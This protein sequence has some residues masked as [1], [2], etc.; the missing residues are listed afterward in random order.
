MRDFLDHGGEV[1]S[2]AHGMMHAKLVLI[3]DKAAL[4]GSANLDYRSLF[5][6]YEVTNITYSK[7][8]IALLSDWIDNLISQSIPYQPSDKKIRRLLENLTR[9]I[10]PIL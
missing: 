6:N 8:F 5:I 10:A 3:D 2:Y 7:Q 4:F 9:T 1:H